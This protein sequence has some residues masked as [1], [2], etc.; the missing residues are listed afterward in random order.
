M[1]S[2]PHRAVGNAL[3]S[4]RKKYEIILVVCFSMEWQ[5]SVV[6]VRAYKRQL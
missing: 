4:H 2:G 3:R 1:S 6:L 5:F